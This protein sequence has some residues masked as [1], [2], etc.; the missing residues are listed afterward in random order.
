MKDLSNGLWRRQN[1]TKRIRVGVEVGVEAEVEVK[2]VVLTRIRSIWQLR[3][4]KKIK[5]RKIV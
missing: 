4:M 2:I 5:I 3:I 1:K